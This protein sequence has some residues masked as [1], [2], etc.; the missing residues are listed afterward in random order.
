MSIESERA[1]PKEHYRQVVLHTPFH[2]RTAALNQLNLWHRWR[3]YTVSDAYYSETLEYTALR[4]STAVFDASPLTKHRISGPD[5]QAFLNRLMTRDVATIAPKRVAYCVWCDDDGQVIDDG[6]LFHLEPGVYR[7]CS[8]ERQADWLNRAAFGFD[9]TLE[10]ESHQ[11]AALAVQGPTSAT[12]LMKAG[13]A[14]ENLKPFELDKFTLDGMEFEISRT[15]Y[16]GDLGYEVFCANEHA[17]FLWDRLFAAGEPYGISPMGTL[18]LEV[19]RL[20]AGFIQAGADFL[21]ADHMIRANRS[22]SPFELDLARLVDFKKP[23]FNGRA[24][25]KK[26]AERGFQRQLLRLKVSG[27]KVAKDAYLYNERREHIGSVTSATWSPMLKQSVAI[28]T[29][30]RELWLRSE[31][32]IAEIYYKKELHWSRVNVPCE[33][34]NGPFFD[35]PRRKANP[36]ARV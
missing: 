15:G 34:V 27:N 17:L 22:R 31:Q 10:E 6:T 7:L 33:V 21:P 18:A 23:F 30:N 11:I 26:E 35:P 32:I 16:T 4:N 29:V 28:A 13:F 14:V 36:P 2:A 24:A 25:L 19:A 3:D 5:S 12:V 20:E 1:T 9:V 8:Q